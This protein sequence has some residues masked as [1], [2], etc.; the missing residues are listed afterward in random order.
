MISPVRNPVVFSID[1]GKEK[2]CLNEK[3]NKMSS[4]TAEEAETNKVLGS[5]KLTVVSYQKNLQAFLEPLVRFV[6]KL[7]TQQNEIHKKVAEKLSQEENDKIKKMVFENGEYGIEKTANRIL[8]FAKALTSED[9]A[10]EGQ[11]KNAV[12]KGFSQAE[13]KLGTLTE[14]SQ[15]TKDALMN[16]IDYWYNNK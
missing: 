4:S 15:K 11:I 3:A 9:K 7:V 10:S 1:I 6:D 5:K 8:D 2:Y 12:K 14:F 13:K 16:K